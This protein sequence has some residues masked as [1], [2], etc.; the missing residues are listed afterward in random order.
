MGIRGSS[1]NLRHSLPRRFSS[2][3]SLWWVSRE[4]VGGACG[5]THG[6]SSKEEGTLSV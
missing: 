2:K 4:H 6:F 3:K 1:F 5:G